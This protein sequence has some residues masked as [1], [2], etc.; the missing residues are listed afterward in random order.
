MPYNPGIEYRGDRYLFEGVAG[1]GQ[2]IAQGVK[3]WRA[4]KEE[5]QFLDGRA[6]TLAQLVAPRVA[7]GGN[8]DPKVLDDL[9]KFPSL[10]LS[11]KRGKLA[12]LE[13][14]LDQNMRQEQAQAVQARHKESTDLQRE[15]LQIQ[16]DQMTASDERQ[17]RQSEQQSQR[18]QDTLGMLLGLT[19][20]SALPTPAQAL[21]SQYP[22][23]DA[24][25]MESL[26]REFTPTARERLA[27]DQGNLD[28]GRE[29]AKNRRDQLANEMARRDRQTLTPSAKASLIKTK[30]ELLSQMAIFPEMKDSLQESIDEIDAELSAGK[31]QAA[32]KPAP[33]PQDPA[34]IRAAVK[35]GT[36][37]REQAVAELKKLGYQ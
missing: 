15:G 13:F 14:L 4:N 2:A 23:A 9:A 35:A 32:P 28:V 10:S 24:K 7:K 5:G 26:L 3:Q 34:S 11:Q 22:N 12:G 37:T 21:Q 33:A 27:I 30:T 6:E 19:D 25:V 36:M 31:V 17:Q 29:H 18:D 1:A 20:Q 8:V 16:R